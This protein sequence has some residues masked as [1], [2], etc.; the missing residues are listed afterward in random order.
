[1]A[2][3]LPEIKHVYQNHHMDS[4]RWEHYTPRNDDIIITTPIKSGTTWMENI[5]MHLIFQDLKI[6]PLGEYCPWPD[7]RFSPIEGVMD[8]LNSQQHR[9]FLQ[10]HLPLDGLPYF[11]AVKYVV[12]AR[13]TRDVFMSLWNHYRNYTPEFLNLLN[14][15]PGRVG[16]QMPICP[17]DIREFW[18]DWVTKGWFEWESEG[19]PFW[20]NLHHT[21][22]W[23]DFHHLPNILMVHFNDLLSDLEGE[24][25]RIATHLEIQVSDETLSKIV[26]ATTFKTMKQN[27]SEI[28]PHLDDL[29]EGGPQT[30]INKGTNGRWRDILTEDDLKLYHDAIERELSP[31]CA[32]WLQHG[33]LAG[34]T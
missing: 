21:Q 34:S 32:H 28:V 12:V 3:T 14:T 27:A 1:M 23:W 2:N 26:E 15:T 29:F 31:E 17:D 13:D 8:L 19:F 16:A 22:A 24:I 20:S 30:F 4:T 5:V 11:S 6:R 33:R 18:H 25:K 10:T 7:A 9:R